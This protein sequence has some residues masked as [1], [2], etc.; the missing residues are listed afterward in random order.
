MTDYVACCGLDCG[1]C[2]AYV[3]TR[4]GDRALASEVAK[5]WSN[6]VEGNYTANDIWCDGCHSGRLHGFCLKC[7]VR[8]CAKGK[9][10]ANCGECRSYPCGPLEA[11][12]GSW[13]EA[14]PLEAKRNL[15]R[16]RAKTP[17]S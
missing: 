7:P 4:S 11:L 3:A 9:R 1:S 2:R 14:S 8:L 16:L 15:D 6:P 17:P 10:L 5:A 13:V 12:W